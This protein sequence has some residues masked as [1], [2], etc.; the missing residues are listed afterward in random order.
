LQGYKFFCF[1][2]ETLCYTG[3]KEERPEEEGSLVTTT[4]A[5]ATAPSMASLVWI[6]R[7]FIS[8]ESF[9]DKFSSS[10]FSRNSTQ[11]ELV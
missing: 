9:S 11:N 8:A 1:D 4:T 2:P 10:N 5:A 6:L 3:T 7:N